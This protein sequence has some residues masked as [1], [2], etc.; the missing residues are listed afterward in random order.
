MFLL[1][2]LGF[3]AAPGAVAAR[4]WG[5]SRGFAGKAPDLRWLLAGSM[6]PDVVDKTVGQVLFKPYFENGR[7]F[8]HTFIFA[9]LMFVAGTY[10]VRRKGD[11]RIILLACGVAGHLVLDRIWIEPT[12]AFWPALGP[13]VRYPSLQTLMEQIA[14]ALGDPI[15]WTTEIGG[16]LL[17][18][19]ALRYLGI[20]KK[21]DLKAFLLH[22]L[23]PSL[24]QF[25]AGY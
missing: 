21:D 12:T 14:E 25:E 23:S 19:L 7:I 8:C 20:R 10:Q 5:E 1:A 6:L 16:V 17:L 13:F 3:T 15:F 24:V 18:V 2:H 4:W 9:L 11:S 22:G